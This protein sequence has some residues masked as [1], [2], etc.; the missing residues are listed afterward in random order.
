MKTLSGHSFIVKQNSQTNQCTF[1]AKPLFSNLRTVFPPPR[2]AY[3]HFNLSASKPFRSAFLIF[4][5][6]DQL[7]QYFSLTGFQHSSQICFSTFQ[8]F[9]CPLS[10][11]SA[12]RLFQFSAF[13]LSSFSVFPLS[14]FGFPVFSF[15]AF[16][17]LG[18]S[19]LLLFSFSV[20]QL[21]SFSNPPLFCF[22]AFLPSSFSASQP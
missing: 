19:V 12:F 5:L 22:S 17:L 4:L 18:F 9:A 15:S 10:S 3:Q 1:K 2:S 14:V 16:P 6:S 8:L 13:L 11:F 7:F 20:S 21:F